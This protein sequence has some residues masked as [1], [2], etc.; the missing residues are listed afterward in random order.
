ML[1]FQR[2][3]RFYMRVWDYVP[4][5]E[6]LQTI[7]MKISH[8]IYLLKVSSVTDGAIL[9]TKILV[10]FLTGALISSFNLQG[11]HVKNQT[12]PRIT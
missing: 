11:K 5:E 9:A 8:S 1:P 3:R 7:L 12:I 10:T 2:N 4:K 6:I